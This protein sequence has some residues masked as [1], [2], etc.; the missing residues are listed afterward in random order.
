MPKKVKMKNSPCVIPSIGNFRME[1]RRGK[2]GRKEVIIGDCQEILAYS[3]QV[4][5]FRYRKEVITIE[6]ENLWCRTY[7]NRVAEVV[8][9]IH[10]IGFHME[11]K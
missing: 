7:G 11:G 4:I 6:G 1:V 8:G 5:S 2:E 3:H 9:T 10:S